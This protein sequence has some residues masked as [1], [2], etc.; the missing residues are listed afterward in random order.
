VTQ[1]AE[2]IAAAFR[3]ACLAELKALKP[4]NVH[5][6]ADG[7]R[8]TVE[9]FVRSAAAAAAPLSKAGARVGKRILDAVDATLASVGANT[10]LGIILLCAPLAAAAE[11]NPSDLRSALGAVLDALD[12]EDANLAFRAIVRAAPAGLGHVARNDVYAPARVSLRQA[13]AEAADRDRVAR[14]YVTSYADV[15]DRGLPLW[16]TATARG[17]EPP[18]VGLAV[19]LGFLSAFPDSHV[20]RKYSLA[21]AEDVR[22]AAA[23]FHAALQTSREPAHHQ[24]ELLAWDAELKA[25]GI[26]PGTSADLTV[27]TLFARELSTIL[28]TAA[29]SD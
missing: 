2:R 25:R 10:N 12:I 5:V 8:M 15:F 17:W 14:Q 26:N 20:V 22:N 29:N 13:M 3:T 11:S 27:A 18:W 6:F 21:V 19:Y 23:K 16:M 28:P 9:Q 7:H 4:G 24:H 1:P